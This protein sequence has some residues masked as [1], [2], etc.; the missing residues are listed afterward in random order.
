MSA[1]APARSSTSQA[2]TLAA[3]CLAVLVLP[4]SLTGT[5]VALPSIA[6]D[7][8][9][10]LAPLQWVVNAYN[11]TFACFMLAAGSMADILGRRRVFL[12]GTLLFG[13]ASLA[14]TLATNVYLLDGMRA[15]AGVGAAAVM[16]AGSAT[17]ATAFTGPALT[18]AFAVLGSAAGAGL[19]LG[20]STAGFLTQ[21]FGWRGVFASHL[22]VA[23]VVLLGIRF[24]PESTGPAGARVDRA[25]TATF[26]LSLLMLMLG[27]V[28]GPQWGWSSASVLGLFAGAVVLLA[29]FYAVEKRVAKPM[30]DI[31]LFARSRF[32]ALCLL[33]IALAFGFVCLLVFL[34]SYITGVDSLSTG[35]T[36]SIML[37]LTLPVLVVP[38]GVSRLVHRGVPVRLVLSASL[39]VVGLGAAL[40]TVIRPGLSTVVLAVPLL[41]IGI[42]MGISAGLVDGVAITSVEPERAGAAAGVFNTTRLA[43]EAL[44]IAA[45]G[46]VLVSLIQ[47]NVTSGIGRFAGSTADDVPG[48][49]NTIASGRLEEAARTVPVADRGA[50]TALLADGYTDA[51]R[52]VLW[53]LAAICVLTAVVVYV[54][55]RPEAGA[56][57]EPAADTAEVEAELGTGSTPVRP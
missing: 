55:L 39:L 51:L 56:D 44:A 54:L 3:V 25:G 14:S 43:S 35:R 4:A 16:T 38:I 33:P 20:P 28:Q 21:A 32:V 9:S 8:N 53:L 34:P 18:R 52:M 42:G 10:N 1:S 49:A 45:V 15:L 37:L 46:S 17:L 40:L 23:V 50:F 31:A 12:G 22:V 19:A 48:L 7:L 24:M 11:L 13:A 29:A 36:G 2:V 47:S 30:F 26:T 57:P 5:S 41:V 27:I 6:T